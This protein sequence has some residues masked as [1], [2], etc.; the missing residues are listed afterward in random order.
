MLIS[1]RVLAMTLT[2]TAMVN[3]TEINDDSN[4]KPYL[5]PFALFV[6]R[7]SY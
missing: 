3:L 2:M 7:P 5:Y 4:V 6:W 1:F